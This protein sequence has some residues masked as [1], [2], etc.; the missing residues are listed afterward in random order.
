MSVAFP[1]PSRTAPFVV[2]SPAS[3]PRTGCIDSAAPGLE[4]WDLGAHKDFRIT[5]K[6]GLTYRA[7]FFNILNKANFAYPGSSVGS[8]TAGTIRSV[9]TTGRQ[10]QFAL[11][12]HW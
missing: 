7:E 5:E 2:A 11:R 1:P 4:T 6:F 12:L 8:L 9:V 10:I 3:R